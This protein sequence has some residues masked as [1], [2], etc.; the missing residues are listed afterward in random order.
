MVEYGGEIKGSNQPADQAQIE[1]QIPL[2]SLLRGQP[3]PSLEGMIL[4]C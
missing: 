1:F 3:T 2:A 4:N